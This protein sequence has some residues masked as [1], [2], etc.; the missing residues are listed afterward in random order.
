MFNKNYTYYIAQFSKYHQKVI[1]G[2]R[3]DLFE[4]INQRQLLRVK[5]RTNNPKNPYSKATDYEITVDMAKELAML[6]K[7][8]KGKIVTNILNA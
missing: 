4:G 7:T 1:P 8:E 6:Q 3:N 5:I 2:G